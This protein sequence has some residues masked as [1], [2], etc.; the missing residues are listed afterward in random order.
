MEEGVLEIET[1]SGD[2]EELDLTDRSIG[3]IAEK[4]G[5]RI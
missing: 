4:V 3:Q 5:E 1:R 2:K